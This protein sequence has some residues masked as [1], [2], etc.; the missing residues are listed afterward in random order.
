MGEPF[1]YVTGCDT[2]FGATAVRLLAD[3]KR[4]VF[5]GYYA[6]ASRAGLE[7]DGN[8]FII[9]VHLDVTSDDSVAAAAALVADTVKAAKGRLEGVVNNAGLMAQV[10]PIE[11]TPLSNHQKMMEVNYYGTVRVTNSVLPLLRRSE[12]RIVNVASVAGRHG[13]SQLGAYSATKHAVEGYSESLRREM[14]PFGVTVHTVEPG[15]FGGT[16]L[17]ETFKTGFE[18]VRCCPPPL[19]V[20]YIFLCCCTSL[21]IRSFSRSS[22]LSCS[23][24]TAS[25]SGTPRRRK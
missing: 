8:G 4:K 21:H 6:E 2:G 16:S 24:T 13:F 9:P 23:R 18:Q 12:G 17:Y 10:G 22:T 14:L 20:A 5:A 19:F 11:W 25:P 3:Q 15:V 1:F 7:A